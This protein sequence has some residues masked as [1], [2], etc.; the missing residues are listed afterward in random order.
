MGKVIKSLCDAEVTH[1]FIIGG[2]KDLTQRERKTLH[3]VSYNLIHASDDHSSDLEQVQ[4][5]A[6]LL[7]RMLSLLENIALLNHL[8]FHLFYAP[9]AMQDAQN[10]RSSP[11]RL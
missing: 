5:S 3:L 4:C 10:T 8:Y 7:H 2:L 11:L 6:V 1:V 9:K